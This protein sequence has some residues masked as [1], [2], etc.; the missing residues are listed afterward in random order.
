VFGVI[1]QLYAKIIIFNNKKSY[2]DTCASRRNFVFHG[3][4]DPGIKAGFIPNIFAIFA[5]IILYNIL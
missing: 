2:P 4:I 1:N 5:G 3:L